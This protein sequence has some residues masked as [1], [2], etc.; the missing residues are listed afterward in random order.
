VRVSEDKWAIDG[1]PDD[2]P[3]IGVDA[4]GVVHVA[5]PTLVSESAGKG[6]FY[7][8]ST[9]GGRTFSLRTRVDGEGGAAHPQIGVAGERVLV[10][11]D[12]ARG[13]GTRAVVTREIVPTSRR[14]PRLGPRTTFGKDASYPSVAATADGAVLTWTEQTA[15]GSD[16]RVLRVR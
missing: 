12:Q 8:N 14:P 10:A 6:V 15:E 4:R 5:W 2:G 16:I 1:C 7:A 13:D 11:W 9:D 3:S